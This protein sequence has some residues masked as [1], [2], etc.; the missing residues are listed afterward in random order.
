MKSLIII[1]TLLTPT[2][3]QASLYNSLSGSPLVSLSRSP[4]SGF[5]QI[6]ERDLTDNTSDDDSLSFDYKVVFLCKLKDILWQGWTHIAIDNV[7]KCTAQPYYC[8]VTNSKKCYLSIHRNTVGNPNPQ[9]AYIFDLSQ[10]HF[11]SHPQ[12][13]IKDQLVVAKQNPCISEASIHHPTLI[14][15]F[16]KSCTFHPFLPPIIN[17]L[18]DE[19][20]CYLIQTNTSEKE[21]TTLLDYFAAEEIDEEALFSDSEIPKQSNLQLAFPSLFQKIMNFVYHQQQNPS[22]DNELTDPEHFCYPSF[23]D[24]QKLPH[25]LRIVTKTNLHCLSFNDKNEAMIRTIDQ[26]ISDEF[27]DHH[28]IQIVCTERQDI[29]S[30]FNLYLLLSPDYKTSYY[31]FEALLKDYLCVDILELA[32]SGK[33]AKPTLSDW[34]EQVIDWK[35][36]A[37]TPFRATI[38]NYTYIEQFF[39]RTSLAHQDEFDKLSEV[40]RDKTKGIRYKQF[41]EKGAFLLVKD[42]KK[43]EKGNLHIIDIRNGKCHFFDNVGH[44]EQSKNGAFLFTK[45]CFEHLEGSLHII[46]MSSGRYHAFDNV[47][48]YWESKDGAFLIA[49]GQDNLHIIE[50]SS[51]RCQTF[52]KARHFT[53]SKKGTFLLIRDFNEGMKGS[54]RIIEIKSGRCHTL[55]NVKD[56]EEFEDGVFLLVKDCNEKGNGHLRIIDMRSGR[57]C[58]FVDNVERYEMSKDGAFLLTIGKGNLRIIE[59]ES[60]KCH[61]F[62]NVERYEVSKDG[63][64]LF[65][66]NYKKK[67]ED[68]LR[69]IEIK[70]GKCHTF[71]NVK[72]YE[73]SK[74]GAF[75]FVKDNKKDKKGNL[76]IVAMDT[77]KFLC[78][79]SSIIQYMH[80][81][82]PS[83]ETLLNT[84]NHL[85]ILSIWKVKSDK[86]VLQ[87]SQETSELFLQR[88]SFSDMQSRRAIHHKSVAY[89]ESVVSPPTNEQS[90]YS[91][92]LSS[93]LLPVVDDQDRF[94]Q[95]YRH[96]LGHEPNG[97]FT[98]QDFAQLT[99]D[100]TGLWSNTF[101]AMVK[102]F[103][104]YMQIDPFTSSGGTQEMHQVA[105]RLGVNI[106]VY[107][108]DPQKDANLIIS[109]LITPKKGRS[110]TTIRIMQDTPTPSEANDPHKKDGVE[111]Q[112]SASEPN[113]H[114]HHYRAY[115]TPFNNKAQK[116][117]KREFISAKCTQLDSENE[118]PQWDDQK[119][120]KKEDK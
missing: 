81:T 27:I 21:I 54:L 87:Y 47:L 115:L 105:D 117:P 25:I 73:E 56:Y 96:T 19:L 86:V 6:T 5:C 50:M 2:V 12:K 30:S 118:F 89:Q 51:G 39:D 109:P 77:C 16:D 64:F 76:R 33:V 85:G 46:E 83:N 69:I 98:P 119:E 20:I 57:C 120:E 82:T 75:L 1:F 84:I 94:N 74:D 22:I 106:Q 52:G 18:Q 3:L 43:D 15:H 95:R 49:M 104:T 97:A 31:T 61:T 103:M 7:E 62:K 13:T 23:Q 108:S 37:N 11:V 8:I 35:E 17:T 68:D 78:K 102:E 111:H 42:T 36:Q 53:N 71:D 110:S 100:L 101:Q 80:T 29:T 90:L 32:H 112:I 58:V 60:G 14:F 114:C 99:K 88:G 66:A 93:Y 40:F 116:L 92:L 91:S 48:H 55:N 38:F 72:Y 45:D 24:P 4:F 67:K 26:D 79:L 63:A 65:V 34:K 9:L 41:S 70:S 113:Q 10:Y 59:I 44:F 28:F 107:T